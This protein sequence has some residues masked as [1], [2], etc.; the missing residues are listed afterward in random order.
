MLGH[1][2]LLFL[3]AP[4]KVGATT[5]LGW[6]GVPECR[7]DD[8]IKAGPDERPHS[9]KG[10]LGRRADGSS[11]SRNSTYWS[12]ELAPSDQT[13]NIQVL[14]DACSPLVSE[15][16]FMFSEHS[17]YNLGCFLVL[18]ISPKET[19]DPGATWNREGISEK[20][21]SAD[22]RL[23]GARRA[24]AACIPPACLC[25]RSGNG[26]RVPGRGS[27]SGGG[28]QTFVGNPAGGNS[29]A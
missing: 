21:V 4:V 17:S 27:P 25:G 29:E 12:R 6:G 16:A 18:V 22:L 8:Q 23:W 5:R 26:L 24:G 20:G 19:C 9:L 10:P 14:K 13:K 2:S 11:V 1:R 3:L 15:P 28:G 7:T